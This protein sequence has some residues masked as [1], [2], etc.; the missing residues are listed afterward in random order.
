V[1]T[2]L[3]G[4]ALKR[5]EDYRFLTGSGTYT[6]DVKVD[7][8]TYAVFVRSPHAH[9]A[10]K[11]IDTSKA[12]QAPGVLA[13]FTGADVAKAKINGLPCGWLITD[14]N[15]QPM[16][17]PAHPVLAQGK[18]RYV[19]DHVAVVIAE[20]CFQAKDAA[21]LV[22]VDYEILP[23]SGCGRCTQSGAPAIRHG[24]RQYLL[25]LGHRRQ[26]RGRQGLRLG[27][28]RHQTGIREQPPGAQRYRAARRPGE[29]QPPMTAT[30]CT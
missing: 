19:G 6:D 7:R 10:I 20:T 3:I 22:Q 18:V 1:T 26:G 13:I 14:V 16:K 27:S 9:A 12:K 25:R 5:R 8:Q 17:E 21:E 24:A 23:G 28:S 11:R 2:N 15:G 30:P 29:L 4:S